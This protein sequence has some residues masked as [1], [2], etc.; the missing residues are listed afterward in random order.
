MEVLSTYEFPVRTYR[1]GSKYD[2]FTVDAI[3]RIKRGDDIFPSD[4]TTDKMIMRLG[5]AAGNRKQLLRSV[6]EDDNN[7]VLSFTTRKKK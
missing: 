3:Y 7:I 4:A 2:V 5:S 1:Y 6:V